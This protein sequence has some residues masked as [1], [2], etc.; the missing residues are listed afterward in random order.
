MG[1]SESATRWL[2]GFEDHTAAVRAL[3]WCPFQS[4]LLASGGGGNDRCI[5]FW[6]TQTGACLNSLG[7][8]SEVC[9][10]MWSKNE[11]ELISSLG[12]M[13]NQLVL[14][15]YPSMVNVA[16]LAGHTSRPLFMSQSP[17]GGMVA[18]AAGDE[19]LKLWNIFGVPQVAK[20]A[21]KLNREPFSDFSRIQ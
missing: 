16:E 12:F 5:K 14:W 2:H 1:S 13:Q 8:G 20:P 18:S 11:H 4:N 10:S 19:M 17:K 21:P 6:N 9:A 7:T 3:A 15:K